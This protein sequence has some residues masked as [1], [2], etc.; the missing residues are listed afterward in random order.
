[1]FGLL[2]EAVGGRE[3]GDESARFGGSGVPFGVFGGSHEGTIVVITTVVERK[4]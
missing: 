1:L 2:A 4:V 3:D